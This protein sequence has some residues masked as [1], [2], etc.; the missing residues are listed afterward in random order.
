[1]DGFKGILSD[2]STAF[3]LHQLSITYP[4]KYDDDMF[5]IAPFYHRIFPQV[6]RLITVD[7]DTEFHVDPAQLYRQFDHFSPEAVVGAANDLAPHYHQMLTGYRELHPDTELGMPGPFQG[8]NVGVLLLELDRMRESKEYNAYL[9]K[10]ETTRLAV[11][12]HMVN[13]HL[14][15][16][17]RSKWRVLLSEKLRETGA[18]GGIRATSGREMCTTERKCPV[19]IMQ[20]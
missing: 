4:D 1:M 11:K 5:Y 17:V 20:A 8:L 7:V 15:E 3:S 19:H 14:G 16:Q 18:G 6:S 13:T 9:T 12:Y 10:E 2:S